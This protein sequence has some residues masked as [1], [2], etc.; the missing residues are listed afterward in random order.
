MKQEKNLFLRMKEKISWWFY[1]LTAKRYKETGGK[2][3]SQKRLGN[4]RK[5]DMIF[6]LALLAYPMLQFIIFYICVNF[7]SILLAFKRYD[8]GDYVFQGFG[9]FKRIFDMLK[10][11]EFIQTALWNSVWVFVFLQVVTTILSL[12]VT[13]FIFKKFPAA[14]FFKIIL[15][16]PSIISAI[17]IVQVFTFF[18]DVAVPKIFGIPGLLLNADTTFGTVLFYNIWYG[19]GGGMLL[20]LGAMNSIDESVL[21]AAQLDGVNSMQ[22]FIFIVF[23]MI[24]PTFTT[25][26]ITGIAGI[27][28][29]QINLY[30]FFGG[31]ANYEHYTFGYYLY[32]ET[33]K[34]DSNY[35]LLSAWGM[36]LTLVVVP[37]T[38]LVRWALE[39]LGPKEA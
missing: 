27:F 15:F 17:V 31:T 10:S 16:L 5:M 29:N 24:Y 7:N 38:F 18:A 6:T 37:L 9:N 3:I 22:E 4:K 39:K 34:G 36:M 2:P 11:E 28:T 13:Y 14:K 20:Y 32:V 26:M 30:T 33:V 21:E 19:L 1:D 12:F 25:F 8:G 35:P 23:P